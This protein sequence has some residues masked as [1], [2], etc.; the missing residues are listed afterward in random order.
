MNKPGMDDSEK[1]FNRTGYAHIA[2]SVGSKEKVDST[3]SWPAFCAPFEKASTR[4]FVF[5]FECGLPF[6]IK[7]FMFI[8]SLSVFCNWVLVTMVT[9]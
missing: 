3:T 8:S 2:F 7:I 1:Q 5:P 4:A 9:V 6:R